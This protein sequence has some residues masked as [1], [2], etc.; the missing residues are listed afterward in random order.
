MESKTSRVKDRD[1]AILLMRTV[2][3]HRCLLQNAVRITDGARMHKQTSLS[4]LSGLRDEGKFGETTWLPAASRK[5]H[6]K[7]PKQADPAAKLVL[8]LWKF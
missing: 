4:W 5:G 3:C 8:N 6:L 2:L 7:L 1:A